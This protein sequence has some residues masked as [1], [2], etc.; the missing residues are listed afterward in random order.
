MSRDSVVGIATGYGLNDRG[1]GVRVPVGVKNFL[2]C[3]LSRLS[4]NP[5]QTPV[6]WVPGTLSS[7]VKRRGREAHHSPPPS[8][9]VKKIWIYTST[10]PYPFMV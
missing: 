4:L 6:Q 5:T 2:V 9:E 1:F 8:A 7:G 10:P 3:T